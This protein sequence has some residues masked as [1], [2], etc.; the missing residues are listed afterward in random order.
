MYLLPP[1]A[2]HPFLVSFLL[3]CEP[4]VGVVYVYQCQTNT[5]TIHSPRRL[6]ERLH[7]SSSTVTTE[8]SEGEIGRATHRNHPTTI[9]TVRYTGNRVDGNTIVVNFCL[10]F[11]P[12]ETSRLR[13]VAADFSITFFARQQSHNRSTPVHS[14]E[15]HPMIA[16]F[17]NVTGNEK[18]LAHQA[19]GHGTAIQHI[20]TGGGVKCSL[21]EQS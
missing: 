18:S 2:H 5:Y 19:K 6:R 7:K 10:E 14:T 9:H 20:I 16:R 4:M 15:N 8:R 11:D 13:F 3:S 21:V 1:A 17:V 12:G